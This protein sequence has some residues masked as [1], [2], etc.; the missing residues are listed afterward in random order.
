MSWPE[1]VHRV[2][3]TTSLGD[4]VLSSDSAWPTTYEAASAD[5][6]RYHAVAL[7]Y[8]PDDLVAVAD[9]LCVVPALSAAQRVPVRPA[10]FQRGAGVTE[11]LARLPA[12][13]TR[14]F[15]HAQ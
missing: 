13:S 14:L 4:D 3:A 10:R 2:R 15:K 11:C 8:L 12:L 7:K 5:D 9:V 6:A 1:V